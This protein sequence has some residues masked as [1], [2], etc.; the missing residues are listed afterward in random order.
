MSKTYRKVCSALNYFKHFLAFVSAVGGCVSISEFALL[1]G[2]LHSELGKQAC[3]I[4][5]EFYNYKFIFKKEKKKHDKTVLLAKTM[6]NATKVLISKA[7]IDEY[8]NH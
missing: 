2:S 3:A 7:L 4:T 1:V 8:I 5:A 6:L